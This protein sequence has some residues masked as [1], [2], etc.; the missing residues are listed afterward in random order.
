MVVVQSKSM[1]QGLEKDAIAGTGITL[2]ARIKVF[3]IRSAFVAPV[4]LLSINK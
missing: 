1:Y 2:T 4:V 3:M